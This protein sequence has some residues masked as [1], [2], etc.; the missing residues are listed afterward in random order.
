M[1]KL[2]INNFSFIT[3]DFIQDVC[4]PIKNIFQ[5]NLFI[6]QRSLICEKEKIV[7]S[8]AY[9]CNN[10]DALKFIL[11]LPQ[12]NREAAKYDFGKERKYILMNYTQP[13]FASLL[14]EKFNINHL[15]SR[16]ER[17]ENNEW[18][19][20]IIGSDLNDWSIVN[21]YLNNIDLLDKFVSYFRSR[22]KRFI[23]KACKNS[24]I[25]GRPMEKC[26]FSGIGSNHIITTQ[27]LSIIPEPKYYQLTAF[28]SKKVLIPQAEMKCL[29]MLSQ[30]RTAKEIANSSGVSPRTVENNIS[31]AKFKLGCNTK[32]EILNIIEE[33]K[34]S[35]IWVL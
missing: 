21:T 35:N 27:K 31:K 8:N 10:P 11:S 33:W 4:N 13:I 29:I 7:K 20:F 14:Y 17:V 9:L 2:L 15:I 25:S 32:S 3:S 5:A 30:G 16:D 23:E 6:Y 28:N 19:H 18:E 26:N 24:F 22:A 1:A 34:K 12:E